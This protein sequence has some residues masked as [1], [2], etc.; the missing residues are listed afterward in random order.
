MKQQDGGSGRVSGFAVEQVDA[1]NF[2]GLVFDGHK[3]LNVWF[4]Y[5]IVLNVSRFCNIHYTIEW[6]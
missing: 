1:V 2:D 5:S 3:R 6:H 4:Y